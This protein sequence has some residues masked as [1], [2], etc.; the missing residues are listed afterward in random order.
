MRRRWKRAGAPRWPACRG[1]RA[2]WLTATAERHTPP[3]R[4]TLLQLAEDFPGL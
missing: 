1:W 2:D 3:D 4:A